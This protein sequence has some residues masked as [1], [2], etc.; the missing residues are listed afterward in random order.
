MKLKKIVT[1]FALIQFAKQKLMK[2]HTT[3]GD[4]SFT[5]LINPLRNAVVLH[6]LKPHSDPTG[7]FLGGGGIFFAFFLV[8]MRVTRVVMT[9]S[10]NF[11]VRSKN[12]GWF[13]S[14]FEHFR[15]FLSQNF[16][17]SDRGIFGTFLVQMMCVTRLDMTFLGDFMVRSGNFGSFLSIFQHFWAKILNFQIGVFLGLFLVQKACN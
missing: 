15:A 7:G 16:A 13:F 9:F 3:N 1:S 12:F 8:Q 10:G 2:V 14:I 11:M 17:F 5:K 4:M 6:G